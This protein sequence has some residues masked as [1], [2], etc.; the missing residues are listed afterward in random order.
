[1]D[2]CNEARGMKLQS[3]F[4][5]PAVGAGKLT[6][7]LRHR[8]PANCTNPIHTQAHKHLRLVSATTEHSY[9]DH[10]Y[11]VLLSPASA[12]SELFICED[13]K[14]PLMAFINSIDPKC[15]WHNVLP[16]QGL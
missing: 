12:V 2:M 10:L 9:V 5:F 16:L 7:H 3:D 14:V 13:S 4:W 1:M 11:R 6:Q 8:Q 15:K